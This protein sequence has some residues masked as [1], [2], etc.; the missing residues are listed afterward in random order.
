MYG[1]KRALVVVAADFAVVVN[2]MF[3][4]RTSSGV[5]SRV[6]N[7]KVLLDV[8]PRTGV[9]TTTAPWIQEP[10]GYAPSNLPVLGTC[11]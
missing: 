5:L 10:M 6:H 7:I 4:C 1:T 3:L 8:I 9:L 11:F 2:I